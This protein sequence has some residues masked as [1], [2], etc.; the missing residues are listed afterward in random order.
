[1]ALKRKNISQIAIGNGFVVMLGRDISLAEQNLKKEK[2][3]QLKL[4]K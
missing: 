2:R 4:Q 1:M 3:K